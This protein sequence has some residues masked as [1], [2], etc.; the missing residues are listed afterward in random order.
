MQTCFGKPSPP[1]FR[2]IAVRT[3]KAELSPSA[4]DVSVPG[5]S[6]SRPPPPCPFSSQVP[7]AQIQNVQPMRQDAAALP[8]VWVASDHAPGV[9]LHEGSALL[10]Y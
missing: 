3:L 10:Q 4:Q 7:D 1:A 6:T 8:G 9:S 5:H 2:R